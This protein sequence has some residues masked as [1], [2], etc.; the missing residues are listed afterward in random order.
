MVSDIKPETPM[1]INLTD[2]KTPSNQ[3]PQTSNEPISLT[4]KQTQSE[5]KPISKS[6]GIRFLSHTERK[7]Y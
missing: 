1:R 4:P 3:R 6:D 5:I 2:Q 7:V